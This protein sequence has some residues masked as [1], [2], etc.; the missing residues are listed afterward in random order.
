[1]RIISL[2]LALLISAAHAEIYECTSS[3]G[4]TIFKDSECEAGEGFVKKLELPVLVNSTLPSR[5]IHSNNLILNPGFDKDLAQ[6]QVPK[7]AWWE[8]TDGKYN[9]GS[10]AIQAIKPADDQYIHETALEQCVPLRGNGKYGLSADVKLLGMPAKKSAIRLNLYWYKSLDCESLGSFADYLEPQAKGGWQTLSRKQLKPTMGA[11][12]ALIKLTQNGRFSADGKVLWDNIQFYPLQKTQRQNPAS[13]P[14]NLPR[15]TP[16]V[17]LIR[18]GDFDSNV[19]GWH[20]S[21]GKTASGRWS[22]DAGFGALKTKV[23]SSEKGLGT[24]VANQ[25]VGLGQQRHYSLSARFLRD[26]KSNQKGGGRLRLTWYGEADCRGSSSPVWRHKDPQDIAGWQSLKVDDL[27][28][29]ADARSARVELIQSVQGRGQF[30][31]YWDSVVLV[32]IR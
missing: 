27:I 5:Y 2:V 26:Y 1:M 30:V 25:C 29:P 10:A 19:K 8:A 16:R 24:G 20:V 21:Q 32:P 14:K 18:N 28:A 7:Y 9:L 13:G 17:N 15:L 6:W 3:S 4:K 23:Q 12:A 22:R 31:G 11:V